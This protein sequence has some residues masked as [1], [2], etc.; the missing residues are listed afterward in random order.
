MKIC[1]FRSLLSLLPLAAALLLAGCGEIPGLSAMMGPRFKPLDS[2]IAAMA[3]PESEN[4]ASGSL[5]CRAGRGLARFG[6]AWRDYREVEFRL[7]PQSRVNVALAPQKE[8]GSMAFQAV[9]DLE[10]QRLLF[11][12]VVEGP[13]EARI[14]CASIYALEDDLKTGIKRTF[15]IPDAL[16]GGSISC[17]Y[18]KQDLQKL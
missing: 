4:S 7:T 5:Y 3:A 13:P 14:A 9:F 2:D 16:R 11:C 6:K 1:R 10:G 18:R 12:P 17:A 15:D 8:G